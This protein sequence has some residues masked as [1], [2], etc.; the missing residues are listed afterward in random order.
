MI[1]T[2]G[3]T[4]LSATSELVVISQQTHQV[5][6]LNLQTGTLYVTPTSPPN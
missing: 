3:K 2:S 6:L 5:K 1:K 4:K